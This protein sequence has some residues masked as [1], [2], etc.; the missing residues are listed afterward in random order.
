M[1]KKKHFFFLKK[2]KDNVLLMSM[3]KTKISICFLKNKKKIFFNKPKFCF[4]TNK[5]KTVFK[6]FMFSRHFFLKNLNSN[7]MNGF[8]KQVCLIFLVFLQ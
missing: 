6:N 4:L 3:K 5:N 1:L 8:F 2:K 7:K